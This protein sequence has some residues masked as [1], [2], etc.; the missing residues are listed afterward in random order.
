MATATSRVNVFIN[1]TQ[2]EKQLQQMQTAAQKTQD[3]LAKIPEGTKEWAEMNAKLEKQNQALT[4]FTNIIE[5]KVNPSLSMMRDG[6]RRLRGEL[7]RLPAGSAEYNKKLAELK[8]ADATL[9]KH[10][11]VVNGTAGA[12]AKTKALMK[13][14]GVAA[15]S[16]LGV[17]MLV[18][19]INNLLQKNAE[20]SDSLAAVRKTTG[21]TAEEVE[22]LAKSF[23][24]L[25]TRTARSELIKIAQVA[26][27]IGVAKDQIAGFVEEVDKAVVAL[28]DEFAGGAEEVAR[29]MGALQKLFGE[30]SGLNAGEAIKRIGSAINELGAAGT[31]TGPEVAEFTKR[32]GALGNM[33]PS[34]S[35]TLGLGAA[36]QELGM[37]AQI[38]SGGL[39]A[40]LLETSKRSTMFSVEMQKLQKTDPNAFLLKLAESFK[41]LDNVQTAQRMTELGISSQEAMKVMGQLANNTDLVREKQELA[42]RSFREGTSLQKEFN[43]MNNTFGANLEKIGKAINKMFVN[44]SLVAFFDNVASGL[45][46]SL[47]P[48][49]DYTDGLS[50]QLQLLH[51]RQLTFNGLIQALKDENLSSEE[52]ARVMARINEEYKDLI[53]YQLNEVSGLSQLNEVQD[54]VNEGLE[55]RIRAKAAEAKLTEI[56][57][58]Q[59]EKEIELEKLREEIIDLKVQRSAPKKDRVNTGSGPG[60]VMSLS[61]TSAQNQA[62]DNT[63]AERQKRLEQ[64]QQEMADMDK[65]YERIFSM[66]LTDGPH[67]K[68]DPNKQGVKSSSPFTGEAITGTV[69][70][71]EKAY[72]EAMRRLQ[73]H[74]EQVEKLHAETLV[75]RLSADARERAAVNMKYDELIAKN[76]AATEAEQLNDKLSY[77]QRQ[78]LAANYN[79]E[80]S[81]L[82]QYRN[83]ELAQLEADQ[84]QRHLAA[85]AT[86]LQ[87]EKAYLNEVDLM[88][89]QLTNNQEQKDA[90]ELASMQEQHAKKLEEVR[91][92]Q[93]E[94]LAQMEL[95]EEERIQ[96]TLQ[97]DQRLAALR[98]AQAQSLAERKAKQEQERTIGREDA[99]A[100]IAVAVNP[101][102]LEVERLQI[103][104]HYQQLYQMAQKYNL[105]TVGLAEA[106]ERSLNELNKKGLQSSLQRE[107][108]VSKARLTMYSEIGNAIAGVA[109]LAGQAG[110]EGSDF[111]KGAA[112]AQILINTAVSV[113]NA[114]AGATSAAATTGPAAPF[115]VGGYIAAMVGS[116]ITAMAQASTTLSGANTPAPPR[117]SGP[118][119]YEGGYT[120][121]GSGVTDVAGRKIAGVV[122]SDEYVVPNRLLR[123]P[124][125]MAMTQSIEA[126]RTGASGSLGMST[127]KLEALMQQNVMASERLLQAVTNWPTV[128]RA[129]VVSKD[130]ADAL[131]RDVIDPLNKAKAGP[132][133]QYLTNRYD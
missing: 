6:V 15:L 123:D 23:S 80:V 53:P 83:A 18:S 45:A 93:A 9:Q 105:D 111:Q 58:R 128:L 42:N 10:T 40:V 130:V 127:D 50:E 78:A 21:M 101:D 77:N 57:N 85:R 96:L 64:A 103:E 110:A 30:T 75:K 36:M 67:N 107:Q 126:V 38:A 68:N 2:S 125:V 3:K 89:A 108:E 25:D 47:K 98:D 7:E 32:I 71:N 43:V 99:S 109:N 55:R 19:G 66:G 59:I 39:T 33:A 37:T 79:A 61:T 131:D 113:S 5:G 72:T 81:R 51:Q 48:M 133:K 73:Q 54:K 29:E 28:G 60:T 4:T 97:Y 69:N 120:G 84:L 52:R 35:Q 26:G 13:D 119:F 16:V 17:G 116:V 14:Y 31:A 56:A 44:S 34:I 114:I 100:A 118:G 106:K 1:S 82:N 122:H 49:R 94:M 76:K 62:I 121:P 132:S 24:K 63:I 92:H 8:Q 112:L 22:T 115:V 20:L 12:W 91:K 117:F 95:S 87:A 124:Q 88:T 27:Q 90:A 41:G 70:E 104:R 65:E 129:Q 11:A 46:D 102:S 74:R 86:A